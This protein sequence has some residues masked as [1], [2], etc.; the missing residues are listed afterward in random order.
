MVEVPSGLS[1]QRQ[2][3]P[4]A[5]D[6]CFLAFSQPL[7]MGFEETKGICSNL[8]KKHFHWAADVGGTGLPEQ[9]VDKVDP[10]SLLVQVQKHT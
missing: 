10:F 3:N 7:L 2:A 9:L 5:T 6:G 4:I 1:T 8:S